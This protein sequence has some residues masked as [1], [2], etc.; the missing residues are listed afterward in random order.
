MKIVIEV[1]GEKVTAG[2][3]GDVGSAGVMPPGPPPAELLARAKKLGAFS[4]GG[5]SFGQGAALA[6]TPAGEPGKPARTAKKAARK[7]AKR[8]AR[9]RASR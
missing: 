7:P 1:D 3:A 9:K 5:C 8:P 6:G 2:G 4:A